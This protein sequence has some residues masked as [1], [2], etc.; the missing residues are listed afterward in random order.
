[1]ETDIEFPERRNDLVRERR[2]VRLCF[3]AL[4]ACVVMMADLISG[5]GAADPKQQ[6]CTDPAWTAPIVDGRP[7]VSVSQ[8]RCR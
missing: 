7:G 2:R 8:F 5:A 3:V 6:P 1:M 4:L